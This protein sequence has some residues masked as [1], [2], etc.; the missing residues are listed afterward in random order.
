VSENNWADRDPPTILHCFA[1]YGVESELL[2]ELGEVYRIGI[3]PHDTNRSTPIRADAH[4]TADGKGWEIPLKPD[5]EFD[6]GVFHPVCS[7]WAA[8]TS[9]SGDADDHQNMIPSARQIAEEHC[10]HHVIENVPRAPLEDPVVLNG[11]MFGLPVEFE[12]AFETSFDVPQPPHERSLFTYEGASETA[13]TSSFYFTERSRLWWSRV[14]GCD[15]W[16]YPK[17]HLAKN[18]IPRAYLDYVLR[19]WVQT[20]EEEIGL[21]EGRVDY[22]DYDERM[23]IRRRREQNHSIYEFLDDDPSN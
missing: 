13:E 1:D 22:S 7:K 14:K 23:E 8:T 20:H 21:D 4:V 19:S 10:R 18:A 11:R 9:I 17:Q 3:D 12:R 6:L 5:V 16:R 15:A 2:A